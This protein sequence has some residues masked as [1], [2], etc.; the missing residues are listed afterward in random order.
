M[1]KIIV[2]IFVLIIACSTPPQS[3]LTS[4]QTEPATPTNA[5]FAAPTLIPSPTPAPTETSTQIPQTLPKEVQ[6]KFVNAGINPLDINIDPTTQIW[7]MTTDSGEIIDIPLSDVDKNFVNF[8]SGQM[9]NDPEGKYKLPD[10]EYHFMPIVDGNTNQMVLYRFNQQTKLWEEFKRLD[11]IV[12]TDKDVAVNV[13]I[14]DI[15]SGNLLR[16]LKELDIKFPDGAISNGW[17]AVNGADTSSIFQAPGTKNAV[18]KA[19]TLNLS[20]DFLGLKKSEELYSLA[21]LNKDKTYGFG[22]IP[23]GNKVV[24]RTL[25][26]FLANGGTGLG[27]LRELTQLGYN[28]NHQSLDLYPRSY[29]AEGGAESN[30]GNYRKTINDILNKG[31][32]DAT[33]KTIILPT[34]N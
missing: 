21:F 9:P 8:K 4:T 10:T 29:V 26:R 23:T 20:L 18:V 19:A 2:V 1:K 15:L 22:N 28:W 13:T 16:T 14:Y 12:I 27:F 31:V 33:A 6:D 7:H 24:K 3:T 32:T 30:G 25:D 11:K 34:G 5:E 17:K